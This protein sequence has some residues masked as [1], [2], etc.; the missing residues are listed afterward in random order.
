MANKRNATGSF[1][2]DVVHQ[3]DPADDFIGS[4]CHQ[5]PLSA[6]PVLLSW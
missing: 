6:Q 3:V 2:Y 4:R 5:L 1:L